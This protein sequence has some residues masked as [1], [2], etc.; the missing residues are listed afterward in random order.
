MKPMK[1]IVANLA[2]VEPQKVVNFSINFNSGT[3]TTV[4]HIPNS[5]MGKVADFLHMVL[6]NAGIACV[7]EEI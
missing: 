5:E 6:L 3:K 4:L 2:P 7:K 1:K